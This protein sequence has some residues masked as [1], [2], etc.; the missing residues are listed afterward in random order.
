MTGQTG[1]GLEDGH[2]DIDF[3]ELC[4]ARLDFPF[5]LTGCLAVGRYVLL[6]YHSSQKVKKFGSLHKDRVLR[7]KAQMR[8]VEKMDTNRC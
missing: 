2:A 8:K 4:L 3:V 7:S 1:S 6:G 5:G